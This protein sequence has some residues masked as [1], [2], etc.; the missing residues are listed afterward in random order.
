MYGALK[1]H[2]AF[3]EAQ[4]AYC[5]QSMKNGLWNPES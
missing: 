1:E 4:D 2:R 5:S 3:Q